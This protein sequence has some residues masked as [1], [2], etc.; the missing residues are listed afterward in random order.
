MARV[1]AG[2]G[3]GRQTVGQKDRWKERQVDRRRTDTEV[4]RLID[5]QTCRQKDTHTDMLM[6]D[7]DRKTDGPNDRQMGRGTVRQTRRG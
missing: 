6:I 5:R 1:T 3:D 7:K 4:D 2:Q